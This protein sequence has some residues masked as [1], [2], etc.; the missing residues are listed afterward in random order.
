MSSSDLSASLR[1]RGYPPVQPN[2]VTPTGANYT[3][4][5]H[6]DTYAYVD[7]SK[8]DCAGKAVLIT[9]GNKGI[10]K[11]IATSY[12][13]AGASHIAITSRSDCSSV[14]V[15]IKNVAL[16]AGLAEP[17]VLALQ[18]DVVNRASV[19]TAAEAVER[20]FG[21]LDILISNAGFLAH[22]ERLLDSDDDEWWQSYETNVRGMYFVAKAFLPLMLKGGDKTI[23]SIASSGS[24]HYHIGGSSY[25]VS[26][27]ALLRLTEFLMADHGDQGLLTYSIHPGGVATDLSSS[28]PEQTQAWLR[29]TTAL[30]GD[31]IAFLTSRRQEWLAGRYLSAMWDMEE[32]FDKKEE[33]IDGDLLKMKMAF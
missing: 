21:R 32:V 12:A 30:G 33:I 4:T 18:V 23:V 3:K 22:Y 17:R 28:L 27:F 19:R 13:K 29:C 1:S 6:H 25:Q 15:D 10:G 2:W 31:T 7:P 26:K 9:G 8:S 11:G 20:E 14:A 16:T 5:L 24:M